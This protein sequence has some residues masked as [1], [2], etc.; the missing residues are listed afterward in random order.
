MD[1]RIA[2]KWHLTCFEGD[3]ERAAKLFAAWT[4]LNVEYKEKNMPKRILAFETDVRIEGTFLDEEMK[5]EEFE[6]TSGPIKSIDFEVFRGC[7]IY[8]ATTENEAIYFDING[9]DNQQL[10]LMFKVWL[11]SVKGDEIQNFFK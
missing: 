2:T 6:S 8:C 1:K 3:P 11:E 9:A 10:S 7:A 4:M 5:Q